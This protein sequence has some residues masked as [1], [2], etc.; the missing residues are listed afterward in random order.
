MLLATPPTFTKPWGSDHQRAVV[1]GGDQRFPRGKSFS[2]EPPQVTWDWQSESAG[3]ASSE[4]L[5]C[6]VGRKK[7]PGRPEQTL[8]IVR[9][10][11]PRASAVGVTRLHT[12]DPCHEGSGQ[13]WECHERARYLSSLGSSS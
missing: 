6:S 10:S 3:R 9:K 11:S 4:L 8:E 7:I 13:R 1:K 2:R 12:R 5:K